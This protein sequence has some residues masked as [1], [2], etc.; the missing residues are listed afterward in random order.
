MMVPTTNGASK[1]IPTTTINNQG[2]YNSGDADTTAQAVLLSELVA[3]KSRAVE[4]RRHALVLLREFRSLNDS[5]ADANGK[6]QD[7]LR[8]REKLKLTSARLEQQRK[9]I[10]ELSVIVDNT[11]QRMYERDSEDARLSLVAAGEAKLVAQRLSANLA[12]KVL[13]L[14]DKVAS[15]NIAVTCR[16]EIVKAWEQRLPQAMEAEKLTNATLRDYLAVFKRAMKSFPEAERAILEIVQTPFSS[17]RRNETRHGGAASAPVALSSVADDDAENQ[18]HTSSPSLNGPPSFTQKK[19]RTVGRPWSDKEDPFLAEI[20]A[21]PHGEGT[22]AEHRPEDIKNLQEKL[23]KSS[24]AVEEIALAE[25]EEAVVRGLLDSLRAEFQAWKSSVAEGRASE[26]IKNLRRMRED[27][28]YAEGDAEFAASQVKE[29]EKDVEQ[30]EAEL[31]GAREIAEEQTRILHEAEE[32]LRRAM[33]VEAATQ[34]LKARIQREEAERVKAQAERVAGEMLRKVQLAEALVLERRP[35]L[36]DAI[37]ERERLAR[38]VAA[39]KASVKELEERYGEGESA[40]KEAVRLIKLLMPVV[41]AKYEEA[42][43]AKQA[44]GR[45]LSL[46]NA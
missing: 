33:S 11:A 7:A 13:R 41:T 25:A 9:V 22:E 44:W 45:F 23:R 40:A 42:R 46:E 10:D 6:I 15:Y 1:K 36:Q 34:T 19:N 37:A 38:K 27:L 35:G 16:D 8:A 5:I 39:L 14:R 20:E 21:P 32:D 30:A 3:Q 12:R 26:D 24:E 18:H 28:E 31:A 4:A 2:L 29:G 17:K 43:A